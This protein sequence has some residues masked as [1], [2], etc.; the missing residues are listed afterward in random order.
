MLDDPSNRRLFCLPVLIDWSIMSV[1]YSCV[2]VNRI[3]L[4]LDHAIIYYQN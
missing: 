4:N 3:I 2:V 1:N